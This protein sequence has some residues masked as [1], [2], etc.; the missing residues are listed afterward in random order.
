MVAYAK[1]GGLLLTFHRDDEAIEQLIVAD[2]VKAVTAAM[3]MLALR[4]ELQDGDKLT[5]E[6]NEPDI[7]R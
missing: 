1:P 3:R 2:G 6:A 5:I 7:E 4:E